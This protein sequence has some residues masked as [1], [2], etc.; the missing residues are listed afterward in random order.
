MLHVHRS[1]DV[2]ALAGRLAALLA[3]PLTDPFQAEHVMVASSGIAR[4]LETYM[5]THTPGR[6]WANVK[7]PYPAAFVRFVVDDVL[8]PVD[9]MADPWDPTRLGWIIAEHLPDLVAADPA[10]ATL[11]TYL[12][13]GSSDASVPE[14]VDRRMLGLS[15][16]LAGLLDRYALFRPAM[17][18]AWRDGQ[19]VLADGVTGLGEHAWQAALYRGLLSQQ[20]VPSPAQRVADAIDQLMTTPPSDAVPVR[21]AV[22]G[23]S[24]L[25]PL[26]LSL[27][28]AVARHREVHLFVPSPSPTLWALGLAGDRAARPKDALLRAAGPVGRDT[29]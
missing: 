28:A 2:P 24:T 20:D 23:L 14:V 4:W 8:G 19:D 7:M 9:V 5:A 21:L 10:L 17:L 12:A 16:Q 29:P 18:A 22:F 25:P 15:Q 11:A 6:V 27:L 26:Q 1:H 13:A 3:D